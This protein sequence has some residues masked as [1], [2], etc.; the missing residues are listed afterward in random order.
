MQNVLIPP[1]ETSFLAI[2]ASVV[3]TLIALIGIGIF[4]Y[5]IFKRLKP[6]LKAAPDRRWNLFGERLGQL[7]KIW[8]MQY[9]HPRYM[10]A[11]VLH[12]LLFAGFLILSLRSLELIFVGIIP[13]FSLPGMGGWLGDVYQVLRAYAATWVFVVAVIAMVRRGIVRPARYEVPAK[14]GKA[15]TGE[16]VFVL[17]MICTLVLILFYP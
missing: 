1:A 14:Y 13:H 4:A 5:M 7:I 12:I 3:Y 15:H 17:A 16:A 10:L 2:P 11:G 6:L 9:R 8:L